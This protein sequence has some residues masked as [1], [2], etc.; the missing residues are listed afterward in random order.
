MSHKC[1]QKTMHI[2]CRDHFMMNVWIYMAILGKEHFRQSAKFL[3][4][5]HSINKIILFGS[6]WW[7]VNEDNFEFWVPL[8]NKWQHFLI[9]GIKIIKTYNLLANSPDLKAPYHTTVCCEEQFEVD[10]ITKYSPVY[11][12]W[13]L[14]SWIWRHLP[15]SKG[16]MANW[17]HSDRN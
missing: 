8:T 15:L 5:F 12:L 14:R 6:T 7:W 9:N 3:F 10:H 16:L 11:W 2:G 17:R 1:H 13:V 4:C